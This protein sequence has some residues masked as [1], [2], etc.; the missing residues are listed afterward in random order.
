MKNIME[1]ND[2]NPQEQQK[3]NEIKHKNIVSI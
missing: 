2:N 1:T 3:A